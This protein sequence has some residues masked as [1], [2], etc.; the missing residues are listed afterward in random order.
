VCDAGS[1]LCF[2]S[3]VMQRFHDNK[4]FINF[5]TCVMRLK[6]FPLHRHLCKK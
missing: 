1:H 6:I 3:Y 5:G 2:F 4:E